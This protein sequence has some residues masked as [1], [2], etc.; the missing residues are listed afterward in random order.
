[1]CRPSRG[2]LWR[3]SVPTGSS[4]RAVPGRYVATN[5]KYKKLR[6]ELEMFGSGKPKIIEWTQM[7]DAL[8]GIGLLRYYAGDLAEGAN[9]ELVY[10]AII[11]LW[12]NKVVTIEPYGWGTNAA[13]WDWQ[14]YSVVITDPDGTPMRSS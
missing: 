12:A 10:T 4:T 13:K 14:A 6:A 11:D 2:C 7:K 3:S 8:A 9:Q 5:P 1:M